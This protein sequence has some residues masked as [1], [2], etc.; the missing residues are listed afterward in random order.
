MLKAQIA[1]KLVFHLSLQIDFLASPKSN[2]RKHC[3][4]VN[5]GGEVE[6]FTDPEDIPI[7]EG[8]EIIMVESKDR[9]DDGKAT[10]FIENKM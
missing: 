3:N 5:L 10:T 8:R 7:E 4:C 9:N 6:D 2:P 1:N